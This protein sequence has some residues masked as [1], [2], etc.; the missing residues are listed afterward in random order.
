MLGEVADLHVVAE[1]ARAALGRERAGEQLDERGF[2]RAIRADEHRALA[3]LGLKLQPAVDREIAVGKSMS[4]SVID[5]EPE[6]GG[7]GKRMWTVFSWLSGASIFSIRSICFSLL[8][9]CDALLALARKRSA[10]SWSDAISFCWFLCAASW[11][12]SRC[13]FSTTYLS[14][15]PR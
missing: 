5:R 15:L 7:C 12:S 4:F 11:I 10:N 13:T 14:Q 3:A 2:A 1:F 9:A 6:R 8:C